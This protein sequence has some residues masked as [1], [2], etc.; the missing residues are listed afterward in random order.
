MPGCS[1]KQASPAPDGEA[2]FTKKCASCH[3][4]NNDMRAPDPN[5]L[6]QMTA[7]SILAALQ[8]GRMKWEAK[9]LSTAQKTA[10]AEYLGVQNVSTVAEMTGVCARDLDPP[11]NLPGWAGWGSDAQNSRFQPALAAG[12]KPGQIKNLKLKWTFGFPGAA[13]TFGQPTSFAGKLFVGSEDG[14]VYAL[15]S[16]TGCMWWSFKASATV[17]TAISIGNQG[18]AALFGDTDGYVYA[19]TVADGSVL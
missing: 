16:T 15:D 19:L 2:L 7:A 10:I 9:F 18:R 13:A 12:L 8:T 6:R 3:Q 11:P 1:K 4:P 14:T 17:K 5:S